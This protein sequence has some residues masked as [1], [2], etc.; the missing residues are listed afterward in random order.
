MAILK[1]F[2][3]VMPKPAVPKL[4]GTPTTSTGQGMAAAQ[5]GMLPEDKQQPGS[6]ATT[7]VPVPNINPGIVPPRPNINP[8][9]PGVGSPGTSVV[10]PPPNIP[11]GNYGSGGPTIQPMPYPNQGAQPIVP[12][13]PGNDLRS[14]QINPVGNARLGETQGA[15]D[16]AVQSLQGAPDRSQLATDLY[17]NLIEYTQPGFDRDIRNIT[18]RNAAG[19]RLGSGMYGSDLVDA[20][21]GRQREL[22]NAAAQL[23]YQ[24][25]SQA[26]GDRLST[27]DALSGLEGQQFG[28]GVQQRDE[29]RGERGYQDYQANQ[30]IDRAVQQRLLEEQLLNGQFGRDQAITGQLLGLG[31]GFDP[32][33]AIAAGGQYAQN[34]ANQYGGAAGDLLTSYLMRQR[35]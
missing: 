20:A 12:F 24:G 19:G 28:Q 13:E 3:Q 6:S 22:S 25:G 15:V 21:T 9:A 29:L 30:G 11:A 4:P 14:S 8:P 16:S 35:G 5:P 2:Q 31:F 23:A 17:R 33:N 27:L 34:Q 32:S 1:Q 26:F 18:Q 7:Q 10:P